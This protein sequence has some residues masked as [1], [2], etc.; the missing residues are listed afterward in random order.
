MVPVPP[1]PAWLRLAW[2]C[3]QVAPMRHDAGRVKSPAEEEVVFAEYV[4][5]DLKLMV[6]PTV[7]TIWK[8]DEGHC[9]ANG[10]G[11]PLVQ[12][13]VN[14]QVPVTSPPHA[15]NIVQSVPPLLLLLLVEQ[16]AASTHA[17]NANPVHEGC[18]FKPSSDGR[19]RARGPKGQR[20][21]FT[22]A[23]SFPI[24]AEEATTTH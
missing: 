1:S 14:V 5:S 9:V 2:S 21:R 16:P 8:V 12:A 11:A 4:P 3:A 22:A 6:P 19:V 18:M 23:I 24:H 20:L 10:F 13:F 7:S 15:L 17:A